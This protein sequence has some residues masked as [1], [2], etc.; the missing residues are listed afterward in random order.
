MYPLHL[1]P[2]HLMYNART[3]VPIRREPSVL[4]PSR[5]SCCALSVRIITLRLPWMLH[6]R[7]L[8]Q[9]LT[10]RLPPLQKEPHKRHRTRSISAAIPTPS[11][12]FATLESPL[13]LL[14]GL[15]FKPLLPDVGVAAGPLVVGACAALTVN[16][17][18]STS[19][20][21]SVPLTRI[22]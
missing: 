16:R 1:R 20:P 8:P 21:K 15:L 9:Y 3:F 18:L 17:G 14:L 4:D 2:V 19:S 11:P 12:I 13:S 10:L 6:H 5:R 22:N 7:K